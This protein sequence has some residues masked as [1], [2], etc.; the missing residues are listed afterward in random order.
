MR[1]SKPFATISYN[2]V[3]F[4]KLKLDHLVNTDVLCFYAFIKHRPEIDERKEHIH[5]YCEP[6]G[7]VDTDMIKNFLEEIDPLEPLKPIRILP[8]RKSQFDDWF[9]YAIHDEKYLAHKGQM[10]K[11]YYRTEDI[12][13]SNIDYLLEL[14]NTINFNK[15]YKNSAIVDAIVAGIPFADLVARGALPIQQYTQAKAFYNDYAELCRAGRETHTPI[16]EEE[17]EQLL[18][19]NLVKEKAE[20]NLSSKIFSALDEIEKGSKIKKKH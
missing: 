6:A 17:Q 8:C 7:L 19:K 9:L 16:T 4:L 5:L 11:Y 20:K 2:T 14:K 18:Q 1:T 12:E 15:I 13:T 10:R 3:D